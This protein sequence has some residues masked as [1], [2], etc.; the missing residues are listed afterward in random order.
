[1]ARWPRRRRRDFGG[2][3]ASAP[4]M[5]GGA[6]P[7]G[8]ADWGKFYVIDIATT[9]HGT[10]RITCKTRPMGT[11]CALPWMGVSQ[12]RFRACYLWHPN[13]WRASDP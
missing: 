8:G 3:Q 1:M 5:A 12:R 7:S 9:M 10:S 13:T 4:V 11:G 6:D 2:G